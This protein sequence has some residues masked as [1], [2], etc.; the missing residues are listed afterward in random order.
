MLTP[1]AGSPVLSGFQCKELPEIPSNSAVSDLH[2]SVDK[3][4]ISLV[5]CCSYQHVRKNVDN[6][7]LRVNNSL[8]SWFFKWM[9]LHPLL[10][11]P[12]KKTRP[13]MSG[14]LASI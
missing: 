1:Y 4:L 13:A 3:I 8:T 11:I 12:L 6:L 2:K 7:L 14:E 9:E 10:L 5:F